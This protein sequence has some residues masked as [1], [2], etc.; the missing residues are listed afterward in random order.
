VSDGSAVVCGVSKCLNDTSQGY[1]PFDY[2]G[3]I[4][5]LV[6]QVASDTHVIKKDNLFIIPSISASVWTP[7]QVWN[8]GIVGTYMSSLYGLAV[9]RCVYV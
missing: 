2:M 3:D 6:D 8:T 4:G 7:E 1:S 5:T 9:E